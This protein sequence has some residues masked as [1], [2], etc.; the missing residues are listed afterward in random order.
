MSHNNISDD[1]EHCEQSRL[2]IATKDLRMRADR[3]PQRARAA[4]NKRLITGL[5]DSQA[6][7]WMPKHN[8]R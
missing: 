7:V 8:G 1:E 5:Y 4:R 2:I 3:A 6:L